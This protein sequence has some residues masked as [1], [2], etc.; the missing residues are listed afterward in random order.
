MST[1]I[2]SRSLP[3]IAR[4]LAS[5]VREFFESLK[6]ARV[7]ATVPLADWTL[8]EKW[9]SEEIQMLWSWFS[10]ERNIWGG[11]NRR[12]SVHLFLKDSDGTRSTLQSDWP[13]P[14][15]WI[16]TGAKNYSLPQYPQQ[17]VRISDPTDF[18][19]KKRSIRVHWAE[20]PSG[21]RVWAGPRKN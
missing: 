20:T 5:Y 17:R 3:A 11:F 16:T 15:R 7:Q 19:N 4:N 21:K 8:E 14:M 18:N 2:D 1:V 6:A 13:P 12:W 10:D 9:N